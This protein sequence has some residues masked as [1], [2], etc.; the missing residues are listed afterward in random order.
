[1]LVQGIFAC[2]IFIDIVKVCT[3]RIAP[4]CTPT[5]N[6]W[7]SSFP[8]ILNDT[9]LPHLEPLPV[10]WVKMIPY[11][12]N[13]KF[14]IKSE[15]KHISS[16]KVH[17]CFLFSLFI[18]VSYF[19]L[20]HGSFSY[21]CVIAFHTAL[22]FECLLQNVYENSIAIVVVLRCDQ[23]WSGNECCTLMDGIGTVK[24][25]RLALLPSIMG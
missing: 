4:I 6:L 9:V 23:V 7:Q 20:G 2:I 18:S 5:S 1:M 13:V 10:W 17:L 16:F 11:C 15:I 14:I 12:F 8:F 21:I 19:L 24:I 3:V 25:G 22:R